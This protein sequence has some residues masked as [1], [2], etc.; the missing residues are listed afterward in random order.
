MSLRLVQRLSLF[1]TAAILFILAVPVWAGTVYQQPTNFGGAYASQ[2]DTNSLGN[3]ATAYDNFT[4]GASTNIT[5][6]SWIGSF[7]N[8]GTGTIT[9][10]TLD[11]WSNAGGAPGTMLYTET[12]GGNAG[13]TFLQIDNAGN[14]TYS[15][16]LSTAFSAAAGT[17]YWLSIVPDMAFPPQW[18]WETG[19]GGDGSAWQCF[20]GKCGSIPNDLAFALYGPSTT[21][22]PGSLILLG[23]GLLGLAGSMRRKVLG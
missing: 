11:F 5:S 15:Y 14:P 22:E 20:M 9:G 10:F 18:G 1:A 12:V 7:F 8:G 19:T 13:Q 23:T 16:S 2:N 3:F 17:T 21:P 6:V 4:L